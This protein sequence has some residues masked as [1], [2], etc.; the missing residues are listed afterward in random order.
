MFILL[1]R[2]HKS[3][4]IGGR[5]SMEH[6]PLS[7]ELLRQ[8]F[9]FPKTGQR[10]RELMRFSP[11]EL[12]LLAALAHRREESVRTLTMSEASDL[13]KISKPAASQLVLRLSIKG[14]VERF[15][16]EKDRRVIRIRLAP[17]AAMIV[18]EHI[19][20]LFTSADRVISAFGEEK[21][22]EFIALQKEFKQLMF[23][24][25]SSDAPAPLYETPIQNKEAIL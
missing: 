12:T 10:Y 18:E 16:D 11:S 20:T 13:L 14:L 22:L 2:I 6:N 7:G 8:L 4:M 9:E 23:E 5:I 17:H 15:H 24:F 19:E 25:L 1:Y 21:S 3:H